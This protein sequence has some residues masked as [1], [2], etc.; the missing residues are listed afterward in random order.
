MWDKEPAEWGP[1]YYERIGVSF[2]PPNHYQKL[3]GYENL[4]F[5]ASQYAGATVDPMQLLA[6]VGSPMT[7]TP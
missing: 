5:F 6:A 4:R 2:E 1:D 7:P 3:T